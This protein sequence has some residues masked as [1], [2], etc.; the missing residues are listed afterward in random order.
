MCKR[1]V[2]ARLCWSLFDFFISGDCQS[3]HPCFFFSFSGSEQQRI[4]TQSWRALFR[5]LT[6]PPLRS[7]PCF[8][9]ISFFIVLFNLKSFGFTPTSLVVCFCSD[10]WT[11]F[12]PLDD[13]RNKKERLVRALP[14][15]VMVRDAIAFVAA[16]CEKKRTLV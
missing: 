11:A 10:K 1:R 4:T 2:H 16:C 7:R 6:R 14:I 15:R 9:S 3:P 5:F 8:G 13:D 12:S